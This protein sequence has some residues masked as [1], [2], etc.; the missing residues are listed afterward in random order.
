MATDSLTSLLST[1]RDAELLTG[2][3]EVARLIDAER[4]L[5]ALKK[6]R[7]LYP[8]EKVI[9][10]GVGQVAEKQLEVA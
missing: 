3:I 9:L 5:E 6:I 10:D 7:K 2:L 1:L 4:P 8:R